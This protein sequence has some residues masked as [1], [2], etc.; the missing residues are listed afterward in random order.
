MKTSKTKSHSVYGPKY[1]LKLNKLKTSKTKSS[2]SLV[3]CSCWAPLHTLKT[4]KT[5]IGELAYWVKIVYTLKTSK[6]KSN[7][8][9]KRVKRGVENKQD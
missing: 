9:N 3:L 7:K 4:S 6:T 1:S 5:K 8:H 2:T